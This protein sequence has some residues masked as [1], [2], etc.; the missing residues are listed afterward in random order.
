MSTF[1]KREDVQ[2]I[3]VQ[4]YITVLARDLTPQG[5]NVEVVTIHARDLR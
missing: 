5:G 2:T 3:R 1:S 4:T